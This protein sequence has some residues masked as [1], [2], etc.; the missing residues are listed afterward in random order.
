[1]SIEA[2]K[3][4]KHQSLSEEQTN[5]VE[6]PES[7]S[8][9][10]SG[11]KVSVEGPL[12]VIEKDFSHMPVIISLA[13]NRVA[14]STSL[15]GRRGIA[16]IGTASKH[17]KNMVKGV[18]S[19][20]KVKMIAVHSHFPITMKVLQDNFLIDNFIGERYPRVV[21]IPRGVEVKVAGDNLEIS[22]V[23]IEKVTQ[24]AG[25]VE[26]ATRISRKDQRIFLDGIY[27]VSKGF[28]DELGE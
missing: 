26:N 28:E 10:V 18:L 27:A 6:I 14:V 23:D 5:F 7:V 22:G 1:M 17:I 15:K 25:S 9:T 13:E 2:Q 8:V 16:M 3:P 24:F 4:V 11:S 19:K 20:Y 21:K 12:G